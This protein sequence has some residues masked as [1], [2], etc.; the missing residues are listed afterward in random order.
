MQE[1]KQRAA[2][3]AVSR[4]ALD[5]DHGAANSKITKP[6]SIH[7]EYTRKQ[8]AFAIYVTQP[9]LF[10]LH[11]AGIAG[12]IQEATC[13]LLMAIHVARCTLIVS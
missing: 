1:G 11:Y 6:S 5:Q 3:H 10:T 13:M 12:H 4:L 2:S 7:A 8:Q 9:I